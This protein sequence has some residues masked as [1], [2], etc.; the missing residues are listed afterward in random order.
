MKSFLIR[1]LRTR[2]HTQKNL[3]AFKPCMFFIHP[4]A[5][6]T[7]SKKFRFNEQWDKERIIHNKVVGSL[8]VAE[9]GSLT[10]GSFVLRAGARLTVN[11]GA[12]L[13]LGSGSINED[14]EI[15]C[16][17]S[18][19]IGNDVVIS[20]R[21]VIRDSDNH[22]IIDGESSEHRPV[23]APITICDRVWIGMNVTIL[24][25]VTIGEGAV[26]AAGSVVNKDI[27]ARCLAAGVPAKVIKT[28]ISWE[29]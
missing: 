19:S 26:I 6:V 15:A 9:G 2:L 20:K 10:V 23:S 29:R 16:F 5:S 11:K 27:P 21:V 13:S 28:D 7:I 12:K 24:K 14:C 3:V 8:Y 25:G 17:D 1:L 4:S 18:I 22:R